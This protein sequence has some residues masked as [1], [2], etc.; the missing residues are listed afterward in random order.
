MHQQRFIAQV[1]ALRDLLAPRHILVI[2]R[3]TYK[4]HPALHPDG[5]DQ[6]VALN[7]SVL[8]RG[9]F[10]KNAVAFP[11]MSRSI[12]TRANSARRRLISICS[13]VACGLLLRF[14]ACRRDAP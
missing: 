1:A 8:H 9:I 10:A 2:T 3:D 11:K 6:L 5:P 14:S 4:Q 7:K 13:A 12:V